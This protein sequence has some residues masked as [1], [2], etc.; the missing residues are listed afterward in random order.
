MNKGF[1]QK[2]NFFPSSSTIF[3]SKARQDYNET[4]LVQIL[5][6][7][8]SIILPLLHNISLWSNIRFSIES[9]GDI[10]TLILQEYTRLIP[11]YMKTTVIL[12]SNNF[13]RTTLML[14]VGYLKRKNTDSIS[15][16]DHSPQVNWLLVPMQVLLLVMIQRVFAHKTFW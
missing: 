14:M 6:K 5:S 9:F 3:P 1:L 13:S 7:I 8:L 16:I 4:R 12:M 2:S 11:V 10:S 15:I